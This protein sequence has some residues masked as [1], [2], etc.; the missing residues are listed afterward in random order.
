MKLLQRITLGV[1]L[2]TS[3][4]AMAP[5]SASP[6]ISVGDSV[7]IFFDGRTALRYQT[8]VFNNPN[9]Q[10]DVSFIIGPGVVIDVGNN[11]PVFN[12][13]VRYREDFYFYTKYTDLNIARA[14]VYLDASY[15]RGPLSTSG[16]FSFVQTQQNNELN[17]GLPQLANTLIKRNLYN[18]YAKGSYAISDKY[19]MRAGA[20]WYREAFTNNSIYGYAYQDRDIYSFP[21][22]LFYKVTPK[23]SIGPGFRYRYTNLQQNS[24]NAHRY[25]ADWFANLAITGEVFP[26]LDVNLNIGYQVRDGSINDDGRFSLVSSF[27]YDLSEKTDLFFDVTKDFETSGAGSSV[28]AIDVGIGARYNINSY[29]FTSA[30]FDYTRNDYQNLAAQ[31]RVDNIYGI[32]LSLGWSPPSYTHVSAVL[33]YG[34]YKNDSNAPGVSYDNNTVNLQLNFRY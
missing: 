25:Y 28:D 32:F 29:L 6:L 27:V 11:S 34:Y 21:V 12:M 13:T 18:A 26:K 10:D 4:G 22:D 19:W 3:L 1:A 2:A 30:E 15:V 23:W 33:S 5:V 20:D 9:A 16:G 14:N 8:N 24:A 7:N 31:G 17:L